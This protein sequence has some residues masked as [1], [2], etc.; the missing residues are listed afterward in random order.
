MSAS[1]ATYHVAP[2]AFRDNLNSLPEE[3]LHDASLVCT[4]D[5]G[6][7]GANRLVLAVGSG[8]FLAEIE[9][10]S[11][12]PAGKS[13][14]PGRS[15]TT[16]EVA[17]VS[18]D[19]M[20]DILAYLHEGSIS[21]EAGSERHKEFVDAAVRLSLAGPFEAA[22][23]ELERSEAPTP[24]LP[25]EEEDEDD[26][27]TLKVVSHVSDVIDSTEANSESVIVADVLPFP[28]IEVEEGEDEET[29]LKKSLSMAQ[30]RLLKE[31]SGSL[32]ILDK[33]SEKKMLKMWRTL[34]MW[35]VDKNNGESGDNDD[36]G[37][38]SDDDDV[39]NGEVV[40]PTT[41]M[42]PMTPATPT[43]TWEVRYAPYLT[44]P[45]RQLRIR[46]KE[47]MGFSGRV[48]QCERCHFWAYYRRDMRRH[49]S[50][51]NH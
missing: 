5:G 50:S 16:I 44:T 12:K 43:K 28:T 33:G 20:R 38:A 29:E 25:S 51:V 35:K 4:A 19:V 13:N 39:S 10:F 21:L 11:G 7:L 37:M 26:N 47:V 9:K 6:V 46:A 41:P 8:H 30:V 27:H 2:G 31:M 1:T 34:K 3:L 40:T 42:T 17:D 18:T 15:P 36:S 32:P 22:K 48:W 24:P 23:L 45:R 49:Q 14:F